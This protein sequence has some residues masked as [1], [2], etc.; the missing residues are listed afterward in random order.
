MSEKTV[1]L[2]S[3]KTASLGG[4]VSASLEIPARLG[5]VVLLRALGE[6][7][8]GVVWLG[9]HELLNKLVAVK[10][11]LAQRT[12]VDSPEFAMFIEGARAAANVRH[13]SLNPVLHADAV[14][15]VPYLVL[16]YIDG[17][18]VS[19]LV[20]RH[21]ALPAAVAGAM[22]LQACEG[23]SELHAKDVVHRD[24]KPS[25]LMIEQNGR[26]VVTDFGLACVKPVGR[27]GHGATIGT[28]AYMAPEMFDGTISPRTDVYALGV[29]LFELLTG[30]VPFRG[31]L[32]ELRVMH[33]DR[34]LPMAPMGERGV[35]EALR[36]VVMR[37]ANKNALYRPKTARHAGDVLREAMERA[38]VR[39]APL[40]TLQALAS[41]AAMTAGADGRVSIVAGNRAAGEGGLDAMLAQ[42]GDVTPATPSANTPGSGGGGATPGTFASAPGGGVGGVTPGY[43]DVLRT[44]AE[45]R[46]EGR[47]GDRATPG[48]GLAGRTPAAA[49]ADGAGASHASPGDAGAVGD[50]QRGGAEGTVVAGATAA[51][52]RGSPQAA[53]KLAPG[54]AV[55][56]W[57]LGVAIGTAVLVAGVVVAEASVTRWALLWLHGVLKQSQLIGG[58]APA[59]LAGAS[60]LGELPMWIQGAVRVAVWSAI[61]PV[62]LYGAV[63]GARVF[64]LARLAPN[65]T[66]RCGWCGHEIGA[67][68]TVC[69]SCRVALDAVDADGEDP[70]DLGLGARLSRAAWGLGVLACVGVLT[71]AIALATGAGGVWNQGFTLRSLLVCVVLG[72]PMFAS[73]VGVY[74]LQ[75]SATLHLRGRTHCPRCGLARAVGAVGVAGVERAGK[76]RRADECRC[77]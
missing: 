73:G 12:S 42:G 1:S 10:F 20:R 14:E 48:S 19:A 30:D 55:R 17:P 60:V 58:E 51:R 74:V 64:G 46:R 45:T 69:P 7:G 22:V 71:L 63:R 40:S 32:D 65:Q 41:G 16:D 18:S 62:A 49:G 72:L 6:G 70:P 67:T 34:E 68:A 77:V 2:F 15:G 57:A 21:G 75:A 56:A 38:G 52:G 9:R 61:A 13:E 24:L 54:G 26:I 43:Y 5:P 37:L 47:P 35:P 31:K 59:M 4:G 23:V 50:A 44:M 25:N 29:T 27:I 76:A 11:L 39:P 33:S 28:P 36:E 66:P 8:M 53:P 3:A